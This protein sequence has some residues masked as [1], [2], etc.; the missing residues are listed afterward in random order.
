MSDKNSALNRRKIL[1]R[2]GAGIAAAVGIGGMGSVSAG[3][4]VSTPS[5]EYTELTNEEQN[6]LLGE[7]V[8]TPEFKK[9]Y[10][11]AV[12]RGSIP[13]EIV[14]GGRVE[15][16]DNKREMVSVKLVDDTA[17]KAYL[18]IGRDD[19]SH[20]SVATLEY[21]T[22]AEGGLIEN[23]RRFT[24]K[25]ESPQSMFLYDS[26]NAV[27]VEAETIEPGEQSRAHIEKLSSELPNRD[28]YSNIYSFG[29][30]PCN[31][32]KWAVPLIC[33]N[34]CGGLSGFACGFF[35]IISGGIGGVGCLTIVNVTCGM[36]SL[37]GCS[38]ELA[39]NV[40]SDVGLC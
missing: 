9:L 5:F 28:N 36:A 1:K 31:E 18:T 10:T 25:S 33:Q 26:D 40:C 37:Y 24:A 30:G 8:K 32:C 39:E 4:T 15:T 23:Q 21:N 38:G 12:K 34:A 6:E 35:G 19:E 29:N 22:I 14:R 3:E 20:V 27:T 11:L 2:A 13:T 17:D 7:L 16:D